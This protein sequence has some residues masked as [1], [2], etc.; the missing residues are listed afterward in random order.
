MHT[1]HYFY[2]KHILLLLFITQ[3]LWIHAEV[4][5]A[6]HRGA[7]AYA[8][9]NSLSA[10]K[11]AFEMDADAIEIDIWKTTDD[12]L[13]IMHDRTTGR[14]CNEN[15]IVPES[16]SKQLRTIRL[17]NG[18]KIP[19]AYEALA[20]VPKGKQIVIEIKTS[21]V[22]GSNT[23]VF[24]MLSD[25]LI[26]T[27][28]EKDAI[29]ISFGY[30]PLVESKKYLPNTPCYYLSSRED[31][32]DELIALC[33]NYGFDGLNLNK[34]LITQEFKEKINLA[35]LDLLVWT[36]DDPEEVLRLKDKVSYITSNKPDL[37][38]DL[39]SANKVK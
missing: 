27:G 3:S 29:I 7:S 38:K 22:D 32:E 26:R 18:E 17:N 15:L 1:I 12:S 4:K 36:V 35:N 37:V 9:E 5:V 21:D 13:V 31:M 14:T 25:L 33:T 2:P 39:L 19:Y 11:L 30:K 6:A 10:F 23:H 28:R 8:L 34:K 16:N 20:L 24:P